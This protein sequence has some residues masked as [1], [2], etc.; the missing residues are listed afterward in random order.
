MSEPETMMINKVE[1]VRKDSIKDPKP[2]EWTGIK[3]VAQRLIGHPVIVR[4]RNEG[5]NAGIVVLA[6]DTGVE[7]MNCRRIWYHKPKDK[8][9]AWYEGVAVSGL[10]DDSKVSGTVETKVIIE[11]YSMTLCHKSAFASIMEHPNVK[12]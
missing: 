5:V 3:G 4:S 1:Y 6:D 2:I 12:S 7:L 8:N 10:S 11:D 9:L